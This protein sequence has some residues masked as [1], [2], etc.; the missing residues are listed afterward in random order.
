MSM[1]NDNLSKYLPPYVHCDEEGKHAIFVN[2][3][4]HIDWATTK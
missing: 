4:S 1:L 3:K 2:W